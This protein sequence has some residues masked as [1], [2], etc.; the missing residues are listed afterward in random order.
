MQYRPFGKTGFQA[1]ALGFGCMR[2][3]IVGGDSKQIDEPEAVRMIR[4]AIDRGVNYVDTAHG[5]HGGNSEIVLGKALADGY[6]DQVKVATKLPSWHVKSADDFDRLLDEQRGKLA[7]EKIDFYLIHNLNSTYWPKLRNLGILDWLDRVRGSDRVGHVGFSFH[8]KFD[9][10]TEIIDG[11]DWDFCQIQYNYMNEDVQAGTP[12]L[13][14]AAA[15]GLAVVIMEPLLGGCI[16]AAPPE[17]V[18]A[19]WDAAPVRRSPAAWALHWLWHKPEVAVVLS[20][21]SSLDQVVENL[22]TADAS[23]V[24]TLSADDLAR[25]AQ[26]REQYAALRPVPCTRCGY[27]MP[28]PQGVDIPRNMQ[29][30]MDACIFGGNQRELNRNIYRGLAEEKRAAACIACHECEEKCPQS[31]AVSEVLETIAKEFGA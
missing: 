7:V 24:G 21:M 22:A 12:G 8:D 10:F 2:L 6:R 29:L 28:C 4:H 13:E 15:K 23:G 18:Q 3:P 17:A 14:Y 16:A 30:Y 25:V 11:Y 31:I 1:S 19:I 26:V 20:G 27:C 9:V 5:Y